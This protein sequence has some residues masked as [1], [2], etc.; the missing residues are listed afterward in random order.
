MAKL[1]LTRRFPRLT[2]FA[3]FVFQ[4]GVRGYAITAVVVMVLVAI[5]IFNFAN[6]PV[7]WKII[8]TIC[9]YVVLTFLSPSALLVLALFRATDC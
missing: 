9:S 7:F 1:P 6:F 8:A 2:H 4:S 3:D 5:V